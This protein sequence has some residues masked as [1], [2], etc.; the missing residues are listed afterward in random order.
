MENAGTGPTGREGGANGTGEQGPSPQ[1]WPGV[2]ARRICK[3]DLVSGKEGALLLVVGLGL[4][5]FGGGTGLIAVH[6]I[7][8]YSAWQ[9]KTW[10]I[11]I[12]GPIA[13]GILGSDEG[14]A[15]R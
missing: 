10:S 12:V 9:G 11:P 7:A 8:A 5:L 14:A 13:R 1:T 6:G 2:P 15:A 3:A 4:G